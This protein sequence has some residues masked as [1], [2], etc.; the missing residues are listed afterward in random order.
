[1]APFVMTVSMTME[2]DR[3]ILESIFHFGAA[4]SL[5]LSEL[6]IYF[7]TGISKKC[8]GLIQKEIDKIVPEK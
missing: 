3:G 2:V 8:D 1:M 7:G 5:R 6:L 4:S